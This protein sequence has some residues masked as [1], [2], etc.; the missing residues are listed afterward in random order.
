MLARG[1]PATAMT[2]RLRPQRLDRDR[3][4][5]GGMPAATRLA[6]RQPTQLQQGGKMMPARAKPIGTPVCFSEKTMPKYSRGT[7]C[8]R[9]WAEAGLIGP[10]ATPMNSTATT[11]AATRAIELRARP[12]AA[13]SSAAWQ[14]RTAPSRTIGP[15]AASAT[16]AATP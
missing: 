10:C 4:R 7:R 16:T 2:S 15:A 1:L 11:V 12:I 8:D 14:M 9:T 6:P 13:I 3:G 5:H